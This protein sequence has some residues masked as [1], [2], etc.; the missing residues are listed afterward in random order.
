MKHSRRNFMMSLG[1]AAVALP[2]IAW[3]RAERYVLDRRQSQ[4][5]FFF[6]IGDND[7]RGTFPIKSADVSL[8]LDRVE[9]SK[10]DIRVD[11]K[12]AKAGDLIT[13][14]ALKS[15]EVLNSRDFPEARFVAT[16]ITRTARWKAI[17]TGNLTLRGVTQ[18]VTLAAEFLRQPGAPT[19]NSMIVVQIKGDL[20][21][22]AFGASGFPNLVNDQ[23]SLDFQ[24]WLNR[25][26]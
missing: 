11:V 23:I 7:G 8:D 26:T 5:R 1:A 18:P 15:P 19:D 21:R 24:V 4:V 9:R 2:Q 17:V 22:N 3:A 20:S 6:N 16:R 25:E 10:V 14:S 13:T 12:K